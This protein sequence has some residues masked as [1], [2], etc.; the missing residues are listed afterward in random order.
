[1]LDFRVSYY[2]QGFYI[3]NILT[4][5]H[6]IFYAPVQLEVAL[7]VSD[8]MDFDPDSILKTSARTRI[9]IKEL[10]DSI[11]ERVPPP[12]QLPDDNGDDVDN[13]TTTKD[14][15][16]A[17]VIDSWFENKRG[18][19]AL[20]RVL[21]GV[22]EENDRISIIEPAS[23]DQI[24]EGHVDAHK[25]RKDNFSVQEI[26]MVLPHRV[27]TRKLTRG[28]MGYV[29]AGLRDPREA[30]PGAILSLHKTIPTLIGNN[31]RLPP[32]V[33]MGQHSVLF[34]SV[35]P[36]EGEGFDEL[37]A[38][39]N[40]LALSDAGLEIHQTGG[41][42]S[43]SG[44]GPFLG[45]GLRVGF[46]GLLHVEV[47]RQR[48]E[49]EFHMEA[50]VTPP[51]V[52]YTIK[53]LP[54]KN[55]KPPPTANGEEVVIEDLIDWPE[56]GHRFKVKEPMVDVRVLTPVEYAGSIM[57]LI[58]RK[59]G[60]SMKTKPIDEFT[61]QITSSMPWADVVTDFHDELKSTST[62]YASFDV[63]ESD[64]PQ[65][66]ADLRKVD[67]LLNG[68]VVDP[69]AFVCHVDVSRAQARVV[70]EKLRDVLPRQ[71]FVTVIQAKADGKIIASERIRAYRKDVL[72]KAG[73]TMGGGDVSRKK[74]L[75]E[76]QKRGKKR[77]QSTG[78]VTLSQAAFRAVISRSG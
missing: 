4:R 70:C 55:Y 78:K 40:R 62:G 7:A 24:A 57:E 45:P 63:A 46:Q 28:Q 61:W 17:K 25:V 34:A 8:L 9:G 77:Q 76:K 29:I 56:Q 22:L 37:F 66:E 12:E 54:T 16:R 73:K 47:F 41:S 71:Q 5:I 32:S 59:R 11:C 58:K 68:E 43:G 1:M 52:P 75:L 31:M 14:I 48:L 18:V 33:S 2:T 42:S 19:I 26:G 74:K 36:M 15:L 35:H 6:W 49:D 39:V 67:I 72:T 44:G 64:P 13:G 53:Y 23:Y 10:L 65:K 27:R 38:A 51:K 30:R 69:L 21:S 60:T 50:V 3:Y 20:V